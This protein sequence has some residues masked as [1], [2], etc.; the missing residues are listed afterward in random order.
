LIGVNN[1][2]LFLHLP[3]TGGNSITKALLPYSQN[4]LYR[5]E[6][7]Q[8]GVNTFSLGHPTLDFHKHTPLRKY[9]RILGARRVKKMFV[10]SVTRNPY[11]RIVSYFFSR[12][13]GSEIEWDPRK[14]EGFVQQVPTLERF[15]SLRGPLGRVRGLRLVNRILDFRRLDEEFEAVAHILLGP[16]ANICLEHLNE[17]L[18]P[19]PHEGYRDYFSSNLRRLV[20]DSHRFEIQKFGYKF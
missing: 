4:F 1:E 12:H 7:P 9:T 13:R 16:D 18:S 15:L 17:S 19:R 8:D 14:F 10:F 2:W 20:E 11:E 5:G 6:T 3:K